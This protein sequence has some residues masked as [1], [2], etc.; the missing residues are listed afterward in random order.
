MTRR[1]R[2]VATVAALV[3]VTILVFVL[4]GRDWWP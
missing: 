1:D 3:I 4:F 2:A